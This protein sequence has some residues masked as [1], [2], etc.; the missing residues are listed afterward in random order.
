MEFFKNKPR[1][2]AKVGTQYMNEGGETF[3]LHQNDLSDCPF[4][5]DKCG[6]KVAMGWDQLRPMPLGS[7]DDATPEEWDAVVI[8]D[9]FRGNK[10]SDPYAAPSIAE[11]KQVGGEHYR[12]KGIQPWNIIDANDLDFY[13]GNALKYLLRYKEKGGVIDLDKAIHYIEKI[14]EN[15]ESNV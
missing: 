12:K 15:Y 4:F 11:S 7:L 14:K 10:P 5:T 8:H 3:T 1:P 9:P 6:T 13:E 2:E